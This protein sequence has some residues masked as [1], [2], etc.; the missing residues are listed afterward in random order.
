MVDFKIYTV[1]TALNDNLSDTNHLYIIENNI[2]RLDLV[3]N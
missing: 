2:N 1:V 3:L